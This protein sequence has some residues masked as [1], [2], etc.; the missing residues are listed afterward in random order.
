MKENTANYWE[1]RYQEQNTG[2]DLGTVS[3]PL[4]DYMNEIQDTSLK[5][6][7]PGAGN[8][9]EAEY[10]YHAGFRNIFVLDFAKPAIQN[11]KKRCP[12]FPEDQLLEQ[13]FFN[14]DMKFDLVLEQTF[15]CALPPNRRSEYAQKMAAILPKNKNLVGLLFDFPLTENGPPFGGSKQ[16]YI[17]YFEPYFIIEEMQRATNS[18]LDRKG[19]ELF[20]KLKRK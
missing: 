16:E 20:F 14:L 3:P 11:F 9:Y 10:L 8:S 2:W 15:F 1:K 6:L 18:H 17:K 13:D 7:I 12:W 5:I 4:K 19:K